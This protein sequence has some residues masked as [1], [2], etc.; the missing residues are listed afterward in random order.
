MKEFLNKKILITGATGS[1]GNK[2]IQTLLSS[3][4]NFK[5]LVV[6]SRDEFKQYNM[7]KLFPEHKYKNIRYFLGDV[8]DYE[9]LLTATQNVDILF[10]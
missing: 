7:K 8:R 10:E 6:Y 9:R 3:K 5:S 4:T 1:F 2:F